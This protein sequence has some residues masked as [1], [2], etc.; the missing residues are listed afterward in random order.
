MTNGNMPRSSV[1]PKDTTASGIEIL[2][3]LARL[4][5]DHLF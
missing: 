1:V 3:C 2:D 5:E 4:S